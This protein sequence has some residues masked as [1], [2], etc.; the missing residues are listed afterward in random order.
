MSSALCASG[1]KEA[2]IDPSAGYALFLGIGGGVVTTVNI[3]EFAE[4]DDSTADPYD[5]ISKPKLNSSPLNAGLAFSDG[6]L[7]D[8]V[9]LVGLS[10][11]SRFP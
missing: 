10:M 7:L 3:E 8:D 6:L 11:M 2:G 4:W 5:Y 1:S 9:T